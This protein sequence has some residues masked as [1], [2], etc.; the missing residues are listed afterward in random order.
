MSVKKKLLDKNGSALITVAILIPIFMLILGA[1]IDI[2]EA[3]M[4]KENLYK[5]CLICAEEGTKAIDIIKA[6][7]EGVNHLDE[8][9]EDAIIF[10]FYENIKEKENLKIMSLDYNVHE[11]DFNPKY[12]EVISKAAYKTS[13]L[14]LINIDTINIHAE[15]IGRLKKID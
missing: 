12:I 4:A 10:Y 8:K 7:H 13:F 11:S 15:A 14:K 5:A 9:F 1:V 3:M 2:G 6:Q